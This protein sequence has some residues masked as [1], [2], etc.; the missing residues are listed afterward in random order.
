MH[1]VREQIQ[2]GR[3]TIERKWNGRVKS[4]L[5]DDCSKY[6]WLELVASYLHK[7]NVLLWPSCVYVCWDLSACTSLLLLEEVLSPPSSLLS[8]APITCVFF[9]VSSSHIWEKTCDI[10]L[11]QTGLLTQCANLLFH[12]FPARGESHGLCGVKLHCV[13]G[14]H[15]TIDGHLCWLHAWCAGVSVVLLTLI[16][17][18]LLCTWIVWQFYFQKL[19]L[20]FL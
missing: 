5:R 1:K 2:E 13:R 12:C 8:F 19:L 15:F 17:P 18:G 4:K 7:L 11:S 10:R 3:E 20:G 9:L 6:K 16:S 14:Q